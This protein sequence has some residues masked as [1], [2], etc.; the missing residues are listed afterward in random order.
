MS[1][2]TL[3]YTHNARRVSTLLI[4]LSRYTATSRLVRCV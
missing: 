1:S 3:F 4:Q 2:V